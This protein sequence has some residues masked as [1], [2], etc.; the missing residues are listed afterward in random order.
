MQVLTQP[1][2]KECPYPLKPQLIIVP[3]IIKSSIVSSQEIVSWPLL[4]E[5]RPQI[6]MSRGHS[7]NLGK[8]SIQ[9]YPCFNN[10]RRKVQEWDTSLLQVFRP[11]RKTNEGN[12]SVVLIKVCIAS[13]KIKHFIHK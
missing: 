3:S 11:V 1:R 13:L 2:D 10:L 5:V 7:S 12:Q 6:K 8:V 9:V 4:L